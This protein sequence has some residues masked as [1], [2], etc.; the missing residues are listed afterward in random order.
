M[1]GSQPAQITMKAFMRQYLSEVLFLEGGL[2][3]ALKMLLLRPGCLSR[4]YCDGQ[5]HG[6]IT[7]L[8]LYLGINLLFFLLIPLLNT[9]QFQIFSFN[10]ESLRSGNSVYQALVEAQ[11]QKSGVEEALY[12]ERF[13]ANLEYSK[14]AFFILVV[15]LFA[16]L[17]YPLYARYRRY[18]VEHL[19]F[20][21]H[22][23]AFLMLNMLLAAAL[24]RVGNVLFHS[25]PVAAGVLGLLTPCAMLLWMTVYLG[26]ALRRFYG[27]GWGAFVLKFPVALLGLLLAITVYAQFLF[28]HALVALI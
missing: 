27:G 10:L 6:R 7:P 5:Q 2:P 8:R 3:G 21:L 22:F 9:E 19:V 13:N 26:I 28:L 11:I 15:P 14:S 12:Q 20:A 16:L 24:F 4:D 23:F 1:K 18:L 25:L 17:L